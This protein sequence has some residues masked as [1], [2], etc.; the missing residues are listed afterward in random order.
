VPPLE[1]ELQEVEDYFDGWWVW[2]REQPTPLKPNWKDAQP[3]PPIAA[4]QTAALHHPNAKV[5]REA[6]GVLDHWANDASA[7]V[8][9]RAL[10]DPVPRVRVVALHGLACERCRSEELCVA[11]VVPA[12]VDAIRSD[13]NAR[14]RHDVVPILMRLA[15]RDGRAV[16]ALVHAAQSDPDELVRETARAA[17]DGRWRDVGSRKALRRRARRRESVPS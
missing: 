5:R 7:V 1:S 8:F 17:L 16:E 4:M 15:S 14:V 13:D 11:D 10:S 12:L 9:A 2:L 6:L 3:A